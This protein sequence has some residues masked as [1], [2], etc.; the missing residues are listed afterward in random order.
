[1]FRHGDNS[2]EMR[3]MVKLG[4][5]PV[6][7]L[8]WATLGDWECLRSLEWEGSSGEERLK[9]VEELRERRTSVGDNDMPFGAIRRGFSADI[10]ATDG[11]LEA[12]FDEAVQ[13]RNISFVMKIGRIYKRDGLP[14]L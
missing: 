11:D 1:M 6:K 4:V 3:L 10:I 8:R 7:V 14:V 12:D 13:P 9:R 2:L 5:E